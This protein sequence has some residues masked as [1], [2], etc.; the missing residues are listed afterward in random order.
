MGVCATASWI[1]DDVVIV[2]GD[3]VAVVVVVVPAGDEHC[4][5][6]TE[7]EDTDGE[8]D[9]QNDEEDEVAD[10]GGD[11]KNCSS[12]SVA[13]V[14]AFAAGLRGN[15]VEGAGLRCAT[16]C[17]VAAIEELRAPV[18]MPCDLLVTTPNTAPP[19]DAPSNG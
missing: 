15:G 7:G 4:D 10:G 2:V 9:G 13:G 8:K 3:I 18:V 17:V 11:V 1:V 16:E 5:C 19:I 6:G 14:T 12:P